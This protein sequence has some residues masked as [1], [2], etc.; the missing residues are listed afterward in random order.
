[1]LAGGDARWLPASLEGAFCR[2]G[3][4]CTPGSR[5]K[6]IAPRVFVTIFI[7]GR[8]SCSFTFPIFMRHDVLGLQAY[9]SRLEIL[10]ERTVQCFVEPR[11]S[12]SKFDLTIGK[13]NVLFNV[14]ATSWDEDVLSF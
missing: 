3:E 7:L 14:A 5:V 9:R 4:L 1:M 11:S 8:L 2:P 12:Q 10:I 13:V 6:P